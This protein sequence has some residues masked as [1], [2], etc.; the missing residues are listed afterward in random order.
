MT[1]GADHALDVPPLRSDHDDLKHAL[2]GGA[3][4]VLVAALRQDLGQGWSVVGHRG[5]PQGLGEASNSTLPDG[6]GD[7]RI[8][9]RPGWRM[10]H[11]ERHRQCHRNYTITAD[12]TRRGG[13]TTRTRSSGFLSWAFAPGV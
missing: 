7:H 9:H 8:R 5:R 1:P 11:P 10:P 12:A 13:A 3:R 4:K 2:G 6:P